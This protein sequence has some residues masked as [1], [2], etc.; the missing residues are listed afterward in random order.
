MLLQADQRNR[1]ATVYVGDLDLQVNEGILWELMLQ[2]GPVVNVFI[3]R[4]KLTRDHQ[5]F[6][7]VE[8][9]L[10][11]DADY[12]IKIMNMVK[13]YGKPIRVNKAIR[14]EQ[15]ADVGAN[16]FVGN[17]D[18]EVDE[19]LLWETFSRFGVLVAAPKIMRDP[20]TQISRGFAF[21]N[22]DSFE[23][24][25][26]AIEQMNG[27]FLCGKAISVTYAFKKD[28]KTERH[29]SM[30]ERILAAN[31]PMRAPG[32]RTALAARRAPTPAIMPNSAP[33]PPPMATPQAIRGAPPPGLRPPAYPYPHQGMP[34]GMPPG[35]MLPPGMPPGMALGGM[36]PGMMPMGPPMGLRPPTQPGYPY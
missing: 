22:Y 34:P 24:A 35:G 19:T 36:P 5:A 29:G 4:D 26:A 9:Q 33:P 28:S 30:A 10:E 8:F 17:L 25:D 20:D 23:A 15:S 18:P 6:G 7:F 13:L 1:D 32:Q 3:P 2:A 12:A 27:Q 21:V 16:L 31:N 11:Q 14:G